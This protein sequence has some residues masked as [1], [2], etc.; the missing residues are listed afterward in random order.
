MNAWGLLNILMPHKKKVNQLS[1]KEC[2]EILFRIGNSSSKYYEHVLQHM[3]VLKQQQ[4]HKKEIK[5]QKHD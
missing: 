3:V 2:E 5:K 1:L 4:S